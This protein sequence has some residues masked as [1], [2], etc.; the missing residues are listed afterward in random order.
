MGMRSNNRRA[1]EY[2][3]A[4]CPRIG[5]QASHTSRM[6]DEESMQS[7]ESCLSGIPGADQ[8]I[9]KSCDLIGRT[10]AHSGR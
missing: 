8:E 3:F 1:S 4:R 9:G 10:A 2:A 7:I 5:P 6:T